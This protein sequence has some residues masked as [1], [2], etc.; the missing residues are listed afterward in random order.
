M[1]SKQTRIIATEERVL[2]QI[3][4]LI[5]LALGNFRKWITV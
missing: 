2:I 5:E 3:Y 4:T 1:Q